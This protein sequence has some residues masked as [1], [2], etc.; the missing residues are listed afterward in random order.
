MN[1][2][3]QPVS[4]HVEIRLPWYIIAGGMI[5]ITVIIMFAF[6]KPLNTTPEAGS[7]AP[8]AELAR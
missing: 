7:S 6:A 3:Q 5:V 1:D 4:P 2:I 8:A